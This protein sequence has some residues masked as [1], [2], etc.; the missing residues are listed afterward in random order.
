MPWVDVVWTDANEGH[1]LSHNVSREEA[2]YI[3]RNPIGYDVSE[4]SERPI[5]FGYTQSGRKIAIVYEPVASI[6]VYPITAYEV[7]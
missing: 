5:V 3:F 4:S 1:L 7:E 2:E 6:T